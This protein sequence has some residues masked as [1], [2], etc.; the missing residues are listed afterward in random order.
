MYHRILI[1]LDGSATSERGLR[2]AIGL[3]EGGPATLFL[4]HVVDIA[5]MMMDMAVAVG[6]EE[7]MD[8]LRR[9]GKELLAKEKN[10]VV[11]CGLQAETV[12]R[13]NMQGP[14]AEAIVEEAG[15]L[16]CDLIVMG[17]HGRS[18]IRRLALGS[19][20]EGVIRHSPVPVLLVRSDAPAT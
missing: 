1:P 12:M 17:T 19:H 15:K 6:S 18:G 5:P 11:E 13:D 8:S 16:A 9:Y 20:A 14:V 10:R 2:E 7:S 3:A 4:L